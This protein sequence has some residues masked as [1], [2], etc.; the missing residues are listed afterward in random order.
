MTRL[1]IP[2]SSLKRRLPMGLSW[3]VHLCQSAPSCV[4][5]IRDQ[6]MS[7]PGEFVEWPP[8][9][10]S[11]AVGLEDRYSRHYWLTPELGVVVG[12][13]ATPALMRSLFM[14]GSVLR[15]AATFF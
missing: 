8:S 6:V 10:F 12:C 1:D 9:R 11:E 13:G 3:M 14:N 15:P 4:L 7:K 5:P 2:R